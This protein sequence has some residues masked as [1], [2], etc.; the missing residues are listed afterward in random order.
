MLFAS[1][2]SRIPDVRGGLD[3]SNTGLGLLL[4]TIAAGSILAMP[5]TGWFIT[6]TSA[7][8]V[9][10]V[11]A[12]LAAVGLA[13]GALGAAVASSVPVAAV[14]LFA[15][16]VG[17][18]T[19][20]VAMNVEGA[21]VE[22]GLRRS[23][24]PRF[25]AGFSLGTI[26][27]AGIG[28]AVTAADAPM[29][30]HLGVLGLAAMLV[31]LRWTQAFLPA[32]DHPEADRASRTAWLEP[33][34]LAVGLM[35][36]CFAVAEGSAN[37]WL[38]LALIDGYDVEHWVGV[39]GY[40]VFVTAM[41]LGRLAGTTLLDRFGRAPVLW[42][43]AATAAGGIVLVVVGDHVLLVGLGIL[44]WGLGASLGF[45]VG[46][47]AAADEPSRAAARVS[48]V[49]TIGYGAFLAGPPLLG[50]LGDV[51]GTLDSLLAVAVLMGPAMLAVFAT[52]G[53]RDN[54]SSHQASSEAV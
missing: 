15:Y 42:G 35:I 21:E 13:V 9:V 18:G 48:V 30:L 33:R 25:H 1:L 37:D 53:A 3:L 14:G 6:R 29:L 16:G 8:A 51:V 43:T 20:D 22:R 7:A 23:V 26:L 4:L 11:A 38:T 27:G 36:L 5:S 47:S 34:T 17:T 54:G 40:A 31:M 32:V 10:R 45:P 46:M 41:T 52:R 39:A 44:A 2:V 24:M 49:S 12:V 19:W 50:A 28:V